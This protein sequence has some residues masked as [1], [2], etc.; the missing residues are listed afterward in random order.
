[1][2]SRVVMSFQAGWVAAALRWQ[3]VL[4]LVRCADALILS[5]SATMRRGTVHGC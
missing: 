3:L 2:G 5:K 1:M 4:R